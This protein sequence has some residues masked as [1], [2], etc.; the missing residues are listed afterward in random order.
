YNWISFYDENS[1]D[2]CD[3]ET[4]S[5]NT[6]KTSKGYATRSLVINRFEKLIN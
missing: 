1:T 6:G 4:Y 2:I 5:E 3:I